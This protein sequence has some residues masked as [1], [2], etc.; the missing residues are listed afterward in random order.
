MLTHFDLHA[1]S[2][3]LAVRKADSQG[4]IYL[5]LRTAQGVIV[6][7]INHT[8]LPN[9]PRWSPDGSRIAFGSNDG[10]LYLYTVGGAAPEVVFRHESLQAGFPEWSPEGSALAFSAW[11]RASHS[12]PNI[13][14]LDL[15]TGLTTQLTDDDNTVD[16][17]PV[18]SPSGRWVA[19]QR[20]HLNELDRPSWVYVV[21]VKFQNC[22][23]VSHGAL[24]RFGWSPDSSLLLVQ[25]G[26]GDATSLRAI[27]RRDA[28]VVWTHEAARIHGGAFSTN[29]DRVLR[30]REDD[31]TWVAFPSSKL[32]DSLPLPAP[33]TGYFTG[34]NVS[35]G[36]DD[37][38][39]FLHE[40]SAIERWQVSGQA[41]T[42]LQE[43]L[44]PGPP[45]SHEEYTVVSSDGLSV[46]IQRFIPPN[47]KAPAVL[48]VHGGPGAPINPDDATM[49][50][51][52]GERYEVICAAY[53]GSAGYGPE[54][55]DANRGEYGRADVWDVVACAQDWKERTGGSRPL[56]LVGYSY[57]GFLGLLVL[58]Q[59]VTL[60]AGGIILWPVTGLHRFP[61]HAHRALPEGWEE[62][63]QA[64]TERSPLARARHIRVPIRICHGAL[65]PVGTVEELSVIQQRIQATG[66]ECTLRVFTDDTHGLR[67]HRE[68]IHVDILR[69]L[70]RF[71][72]KRHDGGETA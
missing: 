45:C 56:V 12:P 8:F 10:L 11:R 5:E 53:R 13:Y 49:R 29:G 42:L 31:L 2:Q 3:R 60:L 4:S 14:L 64:M 26:Q 16:R 22:R 46:P 69:F 66:G 44:E 68:E 37:S 72:L 50:R 9:A 35:L 32:N 67:R 39:Y 28:V 24:Q 54:H 55:Q 48:Y 40:D 63:Y 23:A 25:E 62:R 71:E 19:F 30:I 6:G 18:W 34:P 36:A 15:Q 59:T 27:G 61:S 70:G 43:A 17:F 65:D 33:V 57:G 20:Q 21:D 41:V 1:N 58:S 38:V 47:A 51:L 52:L 7:E